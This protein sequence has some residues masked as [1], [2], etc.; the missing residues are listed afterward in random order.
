MFT[1]GAP[2]KHTYLEQER[3]HCGIQ[4][5]AFAN[6]DRL[7]NLRFVDDLLIIATLKRQLARMRQEL[8]DA[9]GKVAA[10]YAC[11]ENEDIV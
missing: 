9:V 10:D 6:R 5:G 4:L 3:V 8:M 1:E 2:P 11:T 7:S